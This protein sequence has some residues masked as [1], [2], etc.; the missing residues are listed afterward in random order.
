MTLWGPYVLTLYA[1]LMN[2]CMFVYGL[3]YQQFNMHGM[4]HVMSKKL[5][6]S[7]LC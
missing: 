4:F 3:C 5:Q 6:F 2:T 1:S 7:A